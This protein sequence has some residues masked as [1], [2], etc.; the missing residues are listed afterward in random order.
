VDFFKSCETNT[1]TLYLGDVQTLK[2]SFAI[3]LIDD[4]TEDRPIGSIRAEIENMGKKAFSNLSG[5]YYF[6]GLE[7]GNYIVNIK[8]ELYFPEQIPVD[9]S[10]FPDPKNPIVEVNGKPE[11]VLKPKPGYPFPAG[12]TLIRGLI[13][14][15]SGKPVGGLRVHVKGKDLENL[16]DSRGEFVL[17]F[18]NVVNTEQVILIINEET[19]EH[20][21][22][23]EE[24]KTVSAKKILIQ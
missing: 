7:A 1:C 10:A 5:Y 4:Y 17:Y 20:S 22:T 15:G 2:L 21:F 24:G 11:V 13:V 12:A 3:W 19:D 6:T 9:M 23:V 8:P 16:T 14:S 18:K